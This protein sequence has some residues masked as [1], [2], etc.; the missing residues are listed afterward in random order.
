MEKIIK[1]IK[2]ILEGKSIADKIKIFLWFFGIKS[3]LYLKNKDGIFFIRKNSADLWMLSPIGEEEI[4]KYFVLTKGVFLDIGA[5]VG[6]YSIMLGNQLEKKGKVYAFEPEP[7]NL[8]SLNRNLNLNKLKNVHI[9]PLACFDKKGKINFY[10]NNKNTGGHSLIKKSDK[11]ISINANTLD[12]IV[13]VENIKNI[14]LIK[15]DVEGA[16]LNV[17]KGAKEVLKKYKPKIIFETYFPNK[18][19]PYLKNFNYDIKKISK[20][21][22]FAE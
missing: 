1:G 13:K 15:I 8:K 6:K 12:S 7:S 3:N 14:K 5:N 19:L 17:L 2:L 18:V 10:L 21:D 11:K 9:I 22:Y 16:E 20:R 4:R